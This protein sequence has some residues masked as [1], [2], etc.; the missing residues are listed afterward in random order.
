M[1]LNGY[2]K[3]KKRIQELETTN[4]SLEDDLKRIVYLK[5]KELAKNWMARFKCRFDRKKSIIVFHK[6]PFLSLFP[7]SE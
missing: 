4:K 1:K 5:D 7:K 6:F 2:Q 3:L